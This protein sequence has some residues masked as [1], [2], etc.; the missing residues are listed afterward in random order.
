[1]I[2]AITGM[3]IAAVLAAVAVYD[4]CFPRYERP[5][6]AVYPGMYCYERAAS[7]VTR[8]EFY[9]PAGDVRLK[10]YYY[11]AEQPYGLV[12]VS[13]G[14]HAGADDYLPLIVELVRGNFSVFA[15]DGRGTYDSEG[16]STVGMCQALADL[17]ET[18]NYLSSSARFRSLP[19]FLVGH[20]C[21]GYAATSVLSLHKNVK[22]CA[23]IAA[24]NNC[25]TLI[26][27]KG[28]QYAGALASA[29]LPRIFLDVYQKILFG[30]Y[31]ECSGV[32]GI[33]ST[34]I[35]VLLAHGTEDKV[36]SFT[37]QSVVSHRRE[38]KN[39]NVF[40]YIRSDALGGHDSIWHSERSAAYRRQIDEGL[41]ALK[42]EKGKLSRAELAAYYE[43]VD[44]TLYSE[45]NSELTDLILELFKSALKS[46]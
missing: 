46:N 41:A 37:R 5:D 24:P 35:P 26:L 45:A 25:Y 28:E 15:Y 17:D 32:K 14:L 23:A 19:L 10:G 40:Y 9:Y 33:N 34:K 3:S 8:E 1:M 30:K 22:A 12:V 2:A 11:P 4:S 16:D 29:G 31:A 44:H 36:I 39:P 43:G 6:Y 18:L 27:E 20:S 13:H 21:G 42:K 38:I 7:F